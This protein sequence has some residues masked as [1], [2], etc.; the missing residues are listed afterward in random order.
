M[1]TFIIMAM[2]L[3]ASLSYGQNPAPSQNLS[4]GS[5]GVGGGGGVVRGNKTYV[6]DLVEAG[7][8][9]HPFFDPAVKADPEFS[10]KIALALKD[11]PNAPVDLLSRKLNEIYTFCDHATP[12]AVIEMLEL[13]SWQMVDFSLVHIPDENIV[14][15]VLAKDQVQLAA[16]TH[17]AVKIDS[18]RWN[19][20]DDNNKAAL[21]L[22]EAIYALSSNHS[23]DNARAIV[24]YLFSSDIKDKGQSGFININN[25]TLAVV[26]LQNFVFACDPNNNSL[27]CRNG[28]ITGVLFN[29]IQEVISFDG[30]IATL[31]VPDE[32]PSSTKYASDAAGVAK[33]Y[34]A[35]HMKDGPGDIEMQV[36]YFSDG[37]ELDFNKSGAFL[38]QMKFP[39]SETEYR[40]VGGGDPGVYIVLSTFKVKRTQDACETAAIKALGNTTAHIRKIYK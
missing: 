37:F 21:I 5:E 12:S 2:L 6:V 40:Y 34:C 31:V 39:Q 27:D 23:S 7:V 32:L 10:K 3:T 15:D 19:A 30:D 13:Y 18:L 20:L 14:V 8:E 9:D 25:D 4:R 36:G 38:E 16:R 11:V 28:D 29:P 1:K 22:H 35:M 26:G 24:G 33:I 17:Q